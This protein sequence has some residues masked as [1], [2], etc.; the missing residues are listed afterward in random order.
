MKLKAIEKIC[1]ATKTVFIWTTDDGRKFIGDGAAFYLLPDGL[2]MPATGMLD[3]FDVALDKRDDWTTADHAVDCHG[4][5]LFADVTAE[6]EVAEPIELTLGVNGE[7]LRP[8]GNALQTILV[9]EAYFKPLEDERATLRFSLRRNLAGTPYVVVKA[10]LLLRAM[11]TP[12]RL[13]AKLCGMVSDTAAR[14]E[15]TREEYR[16]GDENEAGQSV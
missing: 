16:G 11:F 9:N 3:V 15:R 2:A 4:Q 10:G 5:A 8:V 1:K 13:G 12:V 7:V 6:E 14:L